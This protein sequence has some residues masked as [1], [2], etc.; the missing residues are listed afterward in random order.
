VDLAGA[1]ILVVELLALVFWLRGL[2]R[3]CK[4]DLAFGCVLLVI[5]MGLCLKAS[6]GSLGSLSLP[7]AIFGVVNLAASFV[8][9]LKSSV[10]SADHLLVLG[11]ACLILAFFCSIML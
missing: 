10:I 3:K 1:V 11:A 9:R 8:D 7:L 2:Y 4:S 6:S 5:A